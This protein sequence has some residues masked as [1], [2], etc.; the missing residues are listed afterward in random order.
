MEDR[1]DT[2][3]KR[4]RERIFAIGIVGVL[5]AAVAALLVYNRIQAKKIGTGSYIPREEKITPEVVLLQQYVRVDTTNPP[6]NEIAGARWLGARLAKLGI[7]FEV[8]EAAPGRA[9]LYA[10]IRGTSSGEGLILLNHIDVVPASPADWRFPP[11]RAE[12]AGNML[13]ARGALDMKGIA[14]A[15]LEAFIAVAQQRRP[16]RHD[17]I[18]L[19]AA[20]EEAGSALGV[21]W[22]LEH[23]PDIFAGV[24]YALTEGGITEMEQN[25]LTYYGVDVGSK[26][27]VN[28]DI[29]A[30]TKEQLQRARIHL[31]PYFLRDEPDRILPEVARFFSQIA[32]TRIEGRELLADVHQTIAAGK[33]WLLP[34]MYRLLTQDVVLARAIR[35]EKGRFVMNVF[36]SN[37]PDVS[38]DDRIAWLTREIAPFGATV[39]SVERKEGPAPISTDQTPL[40]ATIEKEVHRAY[41]PVPVG[42]EVLA[43]SASDSR[44]LRPRGILCYGFLPFA[45]DFYQ[46][47]SI[48]GIDER[49]TIDQFTEGVE[50]MR[51][52]VLTH[53]GLSDTK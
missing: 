37:L 49:V 39:F 21:R 29:T 44:F 36:M 40:F 51:R 38:P 41:G 3:K 23:R 45:V 24:K 18:F 6:G 7:P 2:V 17:I 20:D 9:S 22:L 14:I 31:E 27:I 26:Q 8:I 25:D 53:A 32:P 43:T 52:V 1:E 33:F 47:K 5:V 48:H 30:P 42:T 15:Q 50:V 28:L 12:I 19:A 13:W 35:E 16:P 11:F 4:R 46:S 10:R 34:Q